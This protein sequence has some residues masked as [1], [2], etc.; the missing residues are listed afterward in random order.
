MLD[1]DFIVTFILMGVLFI[2]QVMIFKDPNK[3]N[4]APL[5]LGIGGIGAM[6]HLLLYPETENFILVFR[7][8]LLPFFAGL[9]LF[10]IMN[11][12]HQ[13]KQREAARLQ[14][15]FTQ[16]LMKQVGQLKNY[17]AVLEGNQHTISEQEKSMQGVMKAVF[18]NEKE[19]LA[20][21]QGNQDRFVEQIQSIVAS[22][23]EA[24]KAF[25]TFAHQELPDI[26]SVIHRHIDMLRVS[27]QDHFNQIKQAL[28]SRGDEGSFQNEMVALRESVENLIPLFKSAAHQLVRDTGDEIDALLQSFAHQLSALRSQS[29]GISTSLSEDERLIE[30]VKEQ[31]QLVMKQM[32][33]SAKQMDELLNESSRV[34]GL[35]EPLERLIDELSAVH[36][37]YVGAKLQLDRLSASIESVYPSSTA[38]YWLME[39]Y[40]SSR[41][42][43]RSRISPNQRTAHCLAF[44]R[45][46]RADFKAEWTSI[47][48]WSEQNSFMDFPPGKCRKYS[49]NVM[50][51][52]LK[53]NIAKIKRKYKAKYCKICK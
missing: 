3:I 21:I 9:M 11:I 1:L 46:C 29:E 43:L 26:D 33:L 4:Y 5:L 6:I 36:S 32:I 15:D 47:A 17:I 44:S 14:N 27:E 23:E 24:L 40:P 37:D 45:A 38:A 13:S 49:Q 2:R 41:K 18:K 19:A 20:V 52:R 8:S 7:E 12:M 34:K 25:E 28:K 30:G 50:I 16:R 48:G 10:V 35:F 42:S 51:G 39:L 31:S 53:P 22:Q